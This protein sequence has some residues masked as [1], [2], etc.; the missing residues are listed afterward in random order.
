M[1]KVKIEK[2]KVSRSQDSAKG[3]L[4]QLCGNAAFGL[5]SAFPNPLSCRL[6]RLRRPLYQFP[7]ELRNEI[8]CFTKLLLRMPQKKFLAPIR[9]LGLV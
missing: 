3:A 7:L 2:D 1:A 8:I 4:C 6:R 9:L 5:T